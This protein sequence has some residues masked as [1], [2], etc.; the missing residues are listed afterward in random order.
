MA[1]IVLSEFTLTVEIDVFL[2]I[3]W[4][5]AGWYEEFLTEQLKD[6][7]VNVGDWAPAPDKPS[8]QSRT[9]HSFHPAKIS[10]PGLPSHAE[11]N[12]AL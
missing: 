8:A 9:V 7:S 1:P 4:H 3:F 2:D 11:V 10:F 6:I 5:K 12:I